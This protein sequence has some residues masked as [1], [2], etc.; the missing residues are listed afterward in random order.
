M[1]IN[2]SGDSAPIG[3]YGVIGD[4]RTTAL[5]G[6]DGSIDWFPFPA[7]TRRRPSPHSSI[8]RGRLHR[9]DRDRALPGAA[10]LPAR[11]RGWK[12]PSSPTR[13]R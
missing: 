11:H 12:P 13:R 9:A 8:H 6:A 5:V 10:A 1:D 3:S 2:G 7:W 4:L